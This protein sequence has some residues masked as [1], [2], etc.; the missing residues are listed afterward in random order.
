MIYKCSDNYE[1][2]GDFLINLNGKKK[3]S[4]STFL[5]KEFYSIFENF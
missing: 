4:I 3:D 5:F 1:K 2:I